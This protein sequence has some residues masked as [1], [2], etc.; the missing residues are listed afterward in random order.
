MDLLDPSRPTEGGSPASLRERSRPHIDFNSTV[1]TTNLVDMLTNHATTFKASSIF[2]EKD[3]YQLP[4]E[5]ITN[6]NLPSLYTKLSY[7][8]ENYKDCFPPKSEAEDDGRTLQEEVEDILE[9]MVGGENNKEVDQ[10]PG[11]A[12]PDKASSS[13]PPKSIKRTPMMNH[14]TTS[15][16]ATPT[17]TPHALSLDI[18]VRFP[19]LVFS[20]LDENGENN[21]GTLDIG[22]GRLLFSQ[23]EDQEPHYC[24]EPEI[25]VTSSSRATEATQV[26]PPLSRSASPTAITQ[27]LSGHVKMNTSHGSGMETTVDQS[28]R[29]SAACLPSPASDSTPVKNSGFDESESHPA[30]KMVVTQLLNPASSY[31]F[32]PSPLCSSASLHLEDPHEVTPPSNDSLGSPVIETVSANNSS[33][34]EGLYLADSD[35]QSVSD[36]PL[37]PTPISP[38]CAREH[39]TDIKPVTPPPEDRIPPPGIAARTPTSSSPSVQ[40]RFMPAVAALDTVPFPSLSRTFSLPLW[41]KTGRKL[42]RTLYKTSSE[43]YA[44]GGP[45][46]LHTSKNP[47]TSTTAKTDNK[48][49]DV[50]SASSEDA[51]KI[52]VTKDSKDAHEQEQWTLTKDDKMGIMRFLEEEERRRSAEKGSASSPLAEQP[53]SVRTIPIYWKGKRETPCIEIFT[54]SKTTAAQRSDTKDDYSAE[55]TKKTKGRS[56]RKYDSAHSDAAEK[57]LMNENKRVKLKNGISTSSQGYSLPP[58]L[59]PRKAKL[60]AMRA[61]PYTADEE[62]SS[63]CMEDDTAYTDGGT[64]SLSTPTKPSEGKAAKH[65]NAYKPEEASSPAQWSPGPPVDEASICRMP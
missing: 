11:P 4:P 51:Q 5:M 17:P 33:A 9:R 31:D 38:D 58:S 28:E 19:S 46:T 20:E 62:L 1:F 57:E 40:P 25:D 50:R 36:H 52:T 12:T 65:R 16:P 22:K 3:E 49:V 10:D 61:M 42:I 48:T 13:I 45:A 35:A 53:T 60:A 54:R 29:V 8:D 7:A 26:D 30:R 23:A 32:D 37:S 18:I 56:K 15:K 47:S 6:W 55:I 2:W 64:S 41:P 34:K 27:H 14:T 63:T 44:A 43:D 24:V 39:A 21:N 59:L